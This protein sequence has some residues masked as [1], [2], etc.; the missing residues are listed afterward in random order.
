[1]RGRC[2]AGRGAYQP[3]HPGD[4]DR[5]DLARGMRPALGTGPKVVAPQRASL[6]RTAGPG[7]G[8][9]RRAKYGDDQFG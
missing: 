6:R 2:I 3:A 4:P 1:M 5:D 8:G 7:Q 9:K